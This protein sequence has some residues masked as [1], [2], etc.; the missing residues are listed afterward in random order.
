M[1]E[2]TTVRGPRTAKNKNKK[3][4]KIK[5]H[6]KSV[7]EFELKEQGSAHTSYKESTCLV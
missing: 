5:I 2:A 6:K 3:N 7:K 4:K 1:G